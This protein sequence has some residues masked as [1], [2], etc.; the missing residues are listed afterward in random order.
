[1]SAAVSFKFK[2]HDIHV[3]ELGGS[4]SMMSDYRLDDRGSIFG[5]DKGFFFY[6]LR[7][8]RL[9]GP[10]NLLSSGYRESFPRG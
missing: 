7:P 10:P 3:Q 2:Q 9:W 1:M 5:T 6:T 4:V 8:D